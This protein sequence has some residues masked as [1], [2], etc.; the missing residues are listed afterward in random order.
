VVKKVHQ[1]W[2]YN[3]WH[4]GWIVVQ[5]GGVLK[6]MLLKR[7]AKLNNNPSRDKDA[8]FQENKDEEIVPNG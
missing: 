5:L 7:T 6:K 3:F 1:I 2:W 4:T 8:R